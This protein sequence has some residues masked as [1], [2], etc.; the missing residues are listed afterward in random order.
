MYKSKKSYKIIIAVML[1]VLM[2]RSVSFAKSDERGSITI[3][4]SDGAEGTEKQDVVFAYVKVADFVNGE[5][6]AVETDFEKIDFNKVQT[7]QEMEQAAEKLKEVVTIPDGRVKTDRYGMAQIKNLEVGVYLVYQA[8]KAEYENVQPFL[9]TIPT[10]DEEQETMEYHI[11]VMP[12]HAPDI[13]EKPVAPQ[14]NLDSR[15]AELFAVS[16]LSLVL[17]AAV[18]CVSRH[19]KEE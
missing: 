9:V 17:A 3:L 12:K 11:E 19:K 13:P 2:F 18:F 16:A 7:A 15:Y 14:T 4:L 8:D 6:K 5:Y 10:W 1:A